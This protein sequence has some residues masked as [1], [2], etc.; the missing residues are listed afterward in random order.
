MEIVCSQ[1]RIIA[2]P[3]IIGP[4]DIYNFQGVGNPFKKLLIK[5]GHA[6][7]DLGSGLGVDTFLAA[8]YCGAADGTVDGGGPGDLHINAGPG[9]VVGVDFAAKEVRHAQ[10]RAAARGLGSRV[11][12]VHADIERLVEMSE[13]RGSSDLETSALKSGSFDVAISNGAFCL[14][15]NKRKAFAQVYE[16]LRPGGKMAICQTTVLWPRWSITRWSIS[17]S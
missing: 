11:E 1:S 12:F 5:Q 10:E 15:P 6:V 14:I 16:M 3:R 7:L 4:H 2:P 17:R 8:H 9:R 13:K